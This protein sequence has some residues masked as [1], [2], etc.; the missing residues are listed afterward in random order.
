[1]VKE[2]VEFFCGKEVLGD[3]I[4]HMTFGVVSYHTT[5]YKCNFWHVLEKCDL[6]AT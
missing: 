5:N 1:M 2:M 6:F 3:N 4:S